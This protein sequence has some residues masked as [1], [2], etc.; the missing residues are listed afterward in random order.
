MA[1]IFIS[2]SSEDRKCIEPI[3][4]LVKAMRGDSV[5]QDYVDIRAGERWGQQLA[6]AL[7]RCK[8]IL[9]FWCTHSAASEWVRK[10]YE[11]GLAAG[12]EIIPLLLD[13]TKLPELLRPLQRLDFRRPES[14]GGLRK[15]FSMPRRGHFSRETFENLGSYEFEEWNNWRIGQEKRQ[16]E[17]AR[18]IA[19]HLDTIGA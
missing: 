15:F 13:D 7:Q 8:T 19:A 6:Q 3:V 5:F 12:K 9:V 4:G 14:H 18:Q 17:I 16:H 10:E 1:D 2:Y 11:A